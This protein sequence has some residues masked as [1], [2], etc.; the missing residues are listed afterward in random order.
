VSG[1]PIVCKLEWMRARCRA[2][3]RSSWTV[4]L[5]VT[6][7][8]LRAALPAALPSRQR[9]T[10]AVSP[11]PSLPGGA[12]VI[13]ALAPLRA[14]HRPCP[15]RPHTRYAR[16]RRCTPLSRHLTTSARMK[17]FPAH[18]FLAL[19]PFLLTVLP[20]PLLTPLSAP[21]SA[22][23]AATCASTYRP[24][25]GGT[26]PPYAALRS[27]A[28]APPRP[29]TPPQPPTSSP[30]AFLS[31]GSPPRVSPVPSELSLGIRTPRSYTRRVNRPLA[32]GGQ[33][34]PSCSNGMLM[35]LT[36]ACTGPLPSTRTL[37][38]RLTLSS[39]SCSKGQSIGVSH[40]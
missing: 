4:M 25:L 24:N 27:S 5:C 40:H 12:R 36:S 20:L 1:N 30:P 15:P 16:P 29:P 28:W 22:P 21:E 39:N 2:G 35:P 11:L 18:S 19:P 14:H 32:T 10:P 37:M 26:R 17:I 3:R 9:Q 6:C 31:L 8:H 33:N 23:P 13:P 34:R 38:V 7:L